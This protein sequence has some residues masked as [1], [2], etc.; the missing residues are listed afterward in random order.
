MSEPFFRLTRI[1][2]LKDRT[3]GKKEFIDEQSVKTKICNTLEDTVRPDG[4]KVYGETA[5]PAGRYKIKITHSTRWNKPM[6]EIYPVPNF[7]GIR[8]HGGGDPKHTLGCILCGIEA[9]GGTIW[10]CE[11][12]IEAIM[13]ILKKYPDGI[14]IEIINQPYNDTK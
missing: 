1:K 9:A 12:A 6:P 11:P 2:Y 7:S 14:D 8:E 4:I 5:I 3:I 10:N 13:N